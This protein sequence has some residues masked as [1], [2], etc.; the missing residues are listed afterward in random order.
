M[1]NLA[2]RTIEQQEC[3]DSEQGQSNDGSEPR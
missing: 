3:D 1:R 2:T